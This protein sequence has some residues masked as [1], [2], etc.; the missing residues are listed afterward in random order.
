[1]YVINGLV[2]GWKIHFHRFIFQD[3]FQ[4]TQFMTKRL[5]VTFKI[6]LRKNTFLV[7]KGV[8][9]YFQNVTCLYTWYLAGI[10]SEI[11]YGDS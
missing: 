3:A 8:F 9:C 10:V 2:V 7:L 6:A 5:K 11:I 1:M 4:Y